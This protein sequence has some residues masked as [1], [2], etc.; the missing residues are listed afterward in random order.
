[1][2]KWLREFALCFSAGSAG[3]LAKSGLIWLWVRVAGSGGVAMHLA[4][5]QYPKGIYARIVWGGIAAFLFLLPLVRNNWLIRGLVWGAV[6]AAI[7]LIVIPLLG[8]GGVHF[9]LAPTLS[10]LALS[11]FWGVVTAVVLRLL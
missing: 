3:A 4:G 11:C 5:A 7:Q 1:M 10:V 9:T 2:Q 8:H 6:V